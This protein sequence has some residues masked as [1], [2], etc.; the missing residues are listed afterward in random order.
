MGV[1]SISVKARKFLNNPIVRKIAIR[2]KYIAGPITTFTGFKEI[3]GKLAY[4][5]EK[6]TII[7]VSHEGSATGAPILALNICREMKSKYNIIVLLIRDGE[8]RQEFL[9]ESNTLLIPRLGIV[10]K[11][12]VEKSLKKLSPKNKPKYAIINSIVSAGTIQPIRKCGIATITLIHEFACYVRP[13]EI[14][15]NVGI[16]SSEIIFSSPLTHNDIL[17][18]YP[19]LRN[20]KH[21]ILPQGPCVRKNEKLVTENT[22]IE[23]IDDGMRYLSELKEDDIL[24][25]GAGQIQPRKGVDIFI[26]VANHI[27]KIKG[28][29]ALKY[30]WIGDGY[31]PDYDF[32]LSVWLQDQITRSGLSEKLMI[33]RN[34]TVY[35]KMIERADLFLMTSR[36]DPLPNV[37]IDSMYAGIPMLCFE[38]ACGIADYMVR[39]KI[40]KT[41][42][43][44]QYLDVNQMGEKAFDLINNETKYREV[45]K[46]CK[47]R[48][49]EW[50]NIDNYVKKL[51]EIGEK[52]RETEIIIGKEY[53]YLL[54]AKRRSNISKRLNLKEQDIKEYLLRWRSEV[55]PSKPKVGF[56]P[57][58]YKDNN[59]GI[60]DRDPYVHYLQAGSPNGPWQTKVIEDCET[61]NYQGSK[62]KTALHIHVYYPELLNEILAGLSVN[63]NKPDIFIT[64]NNENQKSF[65]ESSV[66]EKGLL[67]KQIV[68]VQNRGRDI[69]P[70]ITLIGRQIENIGYDYYGHMHTKKSNY[71]DAKSSRKWR[72]YLIA[73]LLGTKKIASF[74]CII[75]EFIKDPSIGIIFPEDSTCVGWMS[76]YKPAKELAFKLGIDDIPRSFDFPIGNM[77]WAKNGA[78]KRLYNIGL[79]WEDYPIEPIK[80]DG[81]ILHAIERLLPMIAQAEGYNYRLIKVP[82][83]SRY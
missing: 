1:L 48:A 31:D 8:I 71:I 23:T 50:F 58:I 35:K 16:W 34:T 9:D 33:I 64:Y 62:I 81:T 40:L 15:N 5:K 74:D 2:L 44:S 82:G 39:D 21:H 7:I 10:T 61:P 6:E 26:S 14:M 60:K 17:D 27:N 63:E 45:A 20:R 72:E 38:K 19:Q 54:S 66:V 56:H 73:N 46:T 41:S 28:N 49:I 13:Y 4:N 76:N 11:Q 3:K 22:K 69:G 12:L 83:S 42:L 32:M 77:F 70:L 79:N 68:K 65:I 78:L 51:D 18:K 36:L 55:W 67:L 30:L 43:V 47:Q 25:L 75:N 59:D 80:Y 29:K 52:A 53:K 37:A 57:G 24:I